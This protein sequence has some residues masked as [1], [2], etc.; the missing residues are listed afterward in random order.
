MIDIHEASVRLQHLAT[1]KPSAQAWA[2][3]R[4]A[5]SS[6]WEGLQSRACRVLA[7]WGGREAV[8]EL[9][10]FLLDANA[11]EFGWSIRGV[12]VDS[13]AR[14]VAAE[15][16]D[17]VLNHYFSIPGVLNKHELLPVVRALPIES[18]RSRLLAESSSTDRDNRQAAMKAFAN[19]EYPEVD[20]LALLS[21]LSEDQDS[22]IRSGAQALARGLTSRCT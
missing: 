10:S 20:R 21:R 7:A 1:V 5:L 14:C 18:A 6:K 12:V 3:V 4:Q 13:L 19:M 17:W 2:E 8:N 15:D 16:T 9:R 22:A 11:R